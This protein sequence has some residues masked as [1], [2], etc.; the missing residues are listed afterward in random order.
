MDFVGYPWKEAEAYL[1]QN[2]MEYRC[3]AAHPSVSPRKGFRLNE[4]YW[5]VVRQQQENGV[6]YLV[7]AAKMGKEVFS[8]GLQN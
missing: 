2:Q 5:F 1:Q 4:G 6:Y 3:V 8:D 7:V